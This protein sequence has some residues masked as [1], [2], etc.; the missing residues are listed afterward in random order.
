MAVY[1]PKAGKGKDLQDFVKMFLLTYKTVGDSQFQDARTRYYNALADRASGKSGTTGGISSR[2]TEWLKGK[3]YSSPSGNSSTSGDNSYVSPVSGTVGGQVGDMRSHGARVHAG[4][5]FRAANGTPAVA[6][7]EGKVVRIGDHS[8]GGRNVNYGRTVEVLG[9][10]GHVHRYALH[11]GNAS[12]RVG[13]EI[14][15][16]QPVGIVGGGHLHYEVLKN[17]SPAHAAAIRGEFGSTSTARGQSGNASNFINPAQLFGIKRGQ[18]TQAGKPFSA[19]RSAQQ[20][21]QQPA[22]QPAQQPAQR[23]AQQRAEQPAEQPAKQPAE[24]TGFASNELGSGTPPDPEAGPSSA[25]DLTGGNPP[26]GAE[27]QAGGIPDASGGANMLNGPEM[28]AGGIPDASADTFTQLAAL[29]PDNNDPN[30]GTNNDGIG[31]GDDWSD[32]QTDFAGSWGDDW[33]G[34]D[35]MFAE[36]GGMIEAPEGGAPA[37]QEVIGAAL[38]NVQSSYGLSDGGGALP[39]DDRKQRLTAFQNNEGAMS[40][41]EYDAIIQRVDPEGKSPDANSQAL[42]ELYGF[43]S[44]QGDNST[45]AEV[46]GGFLQAAR[47][48]SQDFGMQAVEALR[49]RDVQGAATALISAYNQVPDGREVTGQ[50][51]QSGV[52]MAVITDVASG[53]VV[54]QMPI[55]P[56]IL[57][58][59][60][61]KFASGDEFYTHLASVAQ[62]QEQVASPAAAMPMTPPQAPTQQAA[63]IPV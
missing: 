20:P 39:N 50:V 19:Q 48:R 58:I 49:K 44:A 9:K 10:D 16:G 57:A 55:N 59:A 18:T 24:E 47:Q 34:G 4:V 32:D 35:T 11:D 21:A 12:V 13:D 60:A 5:D 8:S 36:E 22:E 25:L 62:P 40:P 46:A 1:R 51:N 30:Y 31:I 2:F 14:K 28:Q 3:T 56:Q 42:Q 26:S 37:L 43:F 38:H 27:M 33:G 29:Q 53:Q 23:S 63:A 61:Q 6:T 45:A 17:G 52:G 7:I 54:Q 15:Q 41:E